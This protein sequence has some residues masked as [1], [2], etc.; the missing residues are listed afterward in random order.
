MTSASG[1]CPSFAS[2][3]LAVVDDPVEPAVVG[4]VGHV[5][6]AVL[7][8]RGGS[9]TLRQRLPE[10]HDLVEPVLREVLRHRASVPPDVR[11]ARPEIGADAGEQ[12]VLELAGGRHADEAAGADVVVVRVEVA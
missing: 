1:S 9:C 4:T 7:H 3:E 8:A 12:V 10:A 6:D 2:R 5:R 11:G